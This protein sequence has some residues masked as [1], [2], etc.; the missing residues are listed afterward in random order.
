MSQHTPISAHVPSTSAVAKEA[1]DSP[2]DLASLIQLIQ[3]IDPINSEQARSDLRQA[4]LRVVKSEQSDTIYSSFISQGA[5]RIDPLEKFDFCRVSLAGL[6][7]LNARMCIDYQ[8]S[9]HDDLLLLWTSAEQFCLHLDPTGLE[10]DDSLPVNRFANSFVALSKHLRLT[11]AAIEP[12]RNILLLW[13]ESPVD[14]TGVHA[15]FMEACVAS[16]QYSTGL[17][18]YRQPIE[19]I[20][21]KKYYLQPLDHM[22]YHFMGGM[23]LGVLEQWDEAL[24]AFEIVATTPAINTHAFQLAAYKKHMLIQ[25]L[26]DGKAR[27]LPKYTSVC[28][29][30]SVKMHAEAY[31]KLAKMFPKVISQNDQTSVDDFKDLDIQAFKKDKNYGLLKKLQGSVLSKRILRLKRTYSALTLSDMATILGYPDT[32]ETEKMLETEIL[33]MCS[34]RLI[35][36]QI[37]PASGTRTS[38]KVSFLSPPET[39][40]SQNTIQMIDRLTKETEAWSSKVW[41]LDRRIGISDAYLKKHVKDELTWS[42]SSTNPN[43]PDGQN[44]EED[45]M[46]DLNDVGAGGDNGGGTS[47]TGAGTGRRKTWEDDY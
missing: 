28:L 4:L 12:L 31:T 46:D 2:P 3:S 43:N 42:N 44:K 16:K 38:P 32:S 36:A 33:N 9:N 10:Y 22:R 18:F 37:H 23:C 34:N 41:E 20:Q 17:E 7:I 6:L 35:Y 39:F 45:L 5:V 26:R 13:R 29:Y 15:P 30:R 24:G 11:Q 19:E 8:N 1:A 40:T 14:L 27:S 25:L 47:G 21:S